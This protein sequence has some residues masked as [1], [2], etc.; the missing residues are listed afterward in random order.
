MTRKELVVGCLFL[1]TLLL[2]YSSKQSAAL[3]SKPQ[4][5]PFVGK[6]I[7]ISWD[8]RNG[9]WCISPCHVHDCDAATGML[10]ISSFQGDMKDR[11]IWVHPSAFNNLEVI[12][13]QEANAIIERQEKWAAEQNARQLKKD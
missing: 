12:T 4:V 1:G 8:T 7:R 6:I 11:R 10:C 2:V 3:E 9:M 5:S 13:E